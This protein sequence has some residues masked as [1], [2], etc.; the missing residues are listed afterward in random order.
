[1]SK[2]VH[3]GAKCRVIGSASGPKGAAVGKI[4][5]ALYRW[6]HEHTLHGPIWHCRQADGKDFVTDGGGVGPEA[7]LAEDWLEVIED[8]DNTNTTEETKE[9]ETQ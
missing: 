4:C 5:I 6:D 9:L 8:D 2:P 3:P 7:D 1:M